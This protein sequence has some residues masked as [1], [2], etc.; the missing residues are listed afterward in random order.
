MICLK[1]ML[2]QCR[3]ALLVFLLLLPAL[4][5]SAQPLILPVNEIKPGMHGIAKTVIQGQEIETFGVEVMGIMKNR[6]QAGDLIL[7]RTYGD[8]IQKTGGIAQGMSGSPVY[9]DGKL[10]GAIGYGWSMTD[11]TIGMV[12]PIGDMLKLW[13]MPDRFQPPVEPA[14]VTEDDT[15]ATETAKLPA[16]E[17]QP[18]AT[19]LMVSGLTPSAMDMLKEKLKPLQLMPYAVGEAGDE[20]AAQPLQPGGAVGVQLV[21]GDVNMGALGTVTYAENGKVLAF[22]HPFMKKGNTNFFMTG[23]SIFTVVNSMESPFKLGA[24]GAAVGRIYQDRGA[25]IAGQEGYYPRIIPL[26]VHVNDL[27]SGGSQDAAVQVVQDEQLS[28]I[29]ATTTLFSVM[30]KAMDRMG[31]GTAK[32]SFSISSAQLPGEVLKR[33]NMFYSPA[34]IGEMA[35]GEF[36]DA[37]SLLAANNQQPVSIMD[38]KVD[39]TVEEERKT[40]TIL[41]VKAKQQTAQPGENVELGVKLKPFRGE[42]IYR[43]VTYTVPKEQPEGSLLLEVRGGGFVPLLQMLGKYPGMEDE[44]VLLS[45]L[46]NKNKS[47]NDQVREFTERDRNNEIVVEAME[48]PPGE[49]G[50]SGPAADKAFGKD[51]SSERDKNKTATVMKAINETPKKKNKVKNRVSTDYIVDGDAQLALTIVKPQPLVK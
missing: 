9:I 21:R 29:L 14:V 36:F 2:K 16:G 49:W 20:I 42:P 15:D 48:L 18:L 8:L 24:T 19:P 30:D 33:E 44:L 51:K 22:G 25:G 6:G 34:S 13:D 7:V 5:A 46:K 38:V 37:M 10:V 43:T 11:H 41:E 45:R 39:I 4:A 27:N 31:P 12:T 35:V 17:P 1:R 47:F 50:E 32:V 28:P 40:A 23:A 3:L 26:R